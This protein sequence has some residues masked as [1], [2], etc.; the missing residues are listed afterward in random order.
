MDEFDGCVFY[1]TYE[2]QYHGTG[3]PVCVDDAHDPECRSCVVVTNVCRAHY[4]A[5]DLLRIV[6]QAMTSA[7]TG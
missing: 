3:N 7:P 1:D 6:M 4:P 2:R 5:D